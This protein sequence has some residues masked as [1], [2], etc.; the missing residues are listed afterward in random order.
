MIS[1]T[2]IY[3]IDA[4]KRGHIR[5]T[6]DHGSHDYLNI[7]LVLQALIC[8]PSCDRAMLGVI[9][10]E[11]LF[12]GVALDYERQFPHCIVDTSKSAVYTQ[13][14]G[15]WQLMRRVSADQDAAGN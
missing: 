11:Q 14:S 1:K 4:R 12:G 5:A 13:A 8:G 10:V 7:P 6:V 2:V 3:Q 9:G 15:R